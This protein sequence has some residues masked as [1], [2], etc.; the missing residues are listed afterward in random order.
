[1]R[2]IQFAKLESV[3]NDFVLVAADQVEGLPKQ[4][5]AK[6]VCQR[7]FGIGADGF[8]VIGVEEW[9]LDMAFY[10]PDGT[11]DFCGNGLRCASFFAHEKGWVGTEFGVLQRGMLVPVSINDGEV[12]ST[13]PRATY[14]PSLVPVCSHKPF[15]EQEVFGIKGSAI[16]T[17]ST[18]FV[19]MVD[20]LPES[21]R[22]EE[23]S[24]KIERNP[25]FPER[26]SVIWTQAVNERHLRIRIWE[27]GVGE[28]LGCGTGATAAA[29][30]WC[31]ISGV[32]GNIT[33]TSFGGDLLMQ[34]EGI[35]E[36][37]LVSA[38][39]NLRFEGK[40]AVPTEY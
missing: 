40:I 12:I 9:G 31:R 35:D 17:G 13:M 34:I 25:I 18:H 36:S 16:S 22:F 37:V 4:E 6:F 39:P 26:T 10:N 29:V 24:A 33:V 21:P 5:V 11:S 32:S 23:I 27:R 3:G 30:E 19:V 7:R 14:I 20:E 8:I 38:Q 28:T 1:M 2:E 15:I